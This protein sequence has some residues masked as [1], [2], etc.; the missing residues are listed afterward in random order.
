[1]IYCVFCSCKNCYQRQVII[2]LPPVFENHAVEFHKLGCVHFYITIFRGSRS[3]ALSTPLLPEGDESG[4]RDLSDDGGKVFLVVAIL[5]Q[6][7]G[8][9]VPIT[10]V[11][12]SDYRLTLE[13]TGGQFSR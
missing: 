11:T 2:I 12:A 8:L 7:R 3:H 9:G 1:M 5:A 4:L 6:R 13:E 10:T